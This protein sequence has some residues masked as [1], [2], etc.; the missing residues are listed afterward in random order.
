[1]AITTGSAHLPA[2]GEHQRQEIGNELQAELIEL[3]DLSLLGKQ[4]HWS[5]RGP[6]LQAAAPAAR[7]ADRRLA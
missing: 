2:L 4:L 5:V 6:G 3:I 7:R 1:M